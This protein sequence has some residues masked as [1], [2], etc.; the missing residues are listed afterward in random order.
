MGKVLLAVNGA[1]PS[2]KVFRYALDLCG[3]IRA[4][5]SVLQIIDAAEYARSFEK[6]SH[7]AGKA[8]ETAFMAAAFAESGEHEYA[9]T[10]M[11][12]AEK[13]AQE[14]IPQSRKAGVDCTVSLGTGKVDK[15][16]LHFVDHHPEI[17]LTVLDSG[18]EIEASSRNNLAARIKKRLGVPLVL[19]DRS[20]GGKNSHLAARD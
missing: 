6:R 12:K 20:R 11:K 14:L 16:I 15:E 17:V 5:L 4:G 7:G 8:F 2:A 13:N 10:L 19:F 9:K 3:K 18:D 1:A